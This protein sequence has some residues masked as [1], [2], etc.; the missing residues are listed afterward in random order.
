M[1]TQAAGNQGQNPPSLGFEIIENMLH[2]FRGTRRSPSLERVMA[3]VAQG[4]ERYSAENPSPQ[5]KKEAAAVQQALEDSRQ[6]V[7]DIVEE[8]KGK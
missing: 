1:S 8:A 2:E 7:L 5:A 4:L 6:L 3:A